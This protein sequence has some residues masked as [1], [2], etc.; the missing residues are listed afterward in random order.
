MSVLRAT[1]VPIKETVE[2]MI[3]M[4]ID[5][6]Y[7]SN[8]DQSSSDRSKPLQCKQLKDYD[9]VVVVVIV[10]GILKGKYML[11]LVEMV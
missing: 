10:R 3:F 9:V 1:V 7:S 5:D 11:L 8:N 4:V 2:V 6:H